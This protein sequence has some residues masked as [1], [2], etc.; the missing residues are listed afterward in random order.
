[1][2]IE[3]DGFA[4]VGRHRFLKTP[5]NNFWEDAEEDLWDSWIWQQSN[6]VKTL[7][8]C[9][10]VLNMTD[11]EREAFTG[12]SEQFHVGITPYYAS[13]M[14]PED[15]NCPIRLQ[16]VPQLGEL[17]IYPEDLEDPLNEEE[18]CQRPASLTGIPI[19]YYFM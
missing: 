19:E 12:S 18:I 6:R 4:Q 11:D 14:D 15:P 16:S 2:L 7:N 3:Q 8:T 1:M 9:E 13:L 10:K 17:T 5:R